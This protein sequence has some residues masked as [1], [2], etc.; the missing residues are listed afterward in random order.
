[1]L[2]VLKKRRTGSRYRKRLEARTGGAVPVEVPSH[3]GQ[4]WHSYSLLFSR[5]SLAQK[6]EVLF[7]ERLVVGTV[8]HLQGTD[9][10]AS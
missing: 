10:V 4:S 2:T 1:M 6:L 3:W 7:D 8:I 5:L 9:Q